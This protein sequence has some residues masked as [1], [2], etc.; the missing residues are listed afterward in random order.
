MVFISPQTPRPATPSQQ[1][2]KLL[3]TMLPDGSPVRAHLREF[4]ELAPL[5]RLGKGI[6]MP[7]AQVRAAA[8]EIGQMAEAERNYMQ[9]YADDFDVVKA[10]ALKQLGPQSNDNHAAHEFTSHDDSARMLSMVSE[11]L[12]AIA[13]SMSVGISGFGR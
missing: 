7:Q 13:N 4:P 6:N 9:G 5:D 11:R 10:A 2:N 8:A 3:D 1:A 12:Q